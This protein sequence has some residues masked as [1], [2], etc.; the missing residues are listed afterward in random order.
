[1]ALIAL[2]V[3][4]NTCWVWT[5]CYAKILSTN[6]CYVFVIKWLWWTLYSLYFPDIC[7]V[8]SLFKHP[9]SRNRSTLHYQP[10]CNHAVYDTNQ[11]EEV[12]LFRNPTLATDGLRTGN[13]ASQ[14][15]TN[16]RSHPCAQ[17]TAN[18]RVFA[19]MAPFI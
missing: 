13:I 9:L 7:A 19:M 3:H 2:V 16:T 8:F 11:I 6:I 17:I 4:S 1:M 12:E 15:D 14:L 5:V 10:H 18:A